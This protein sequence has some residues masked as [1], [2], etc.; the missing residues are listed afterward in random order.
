MDIN[1]N[2][3]PVNLALDR[4]TAIGIGNQVFLAGENTGAILRFQDE[5]PTVTGEG[6]DTA[7][8]FSALWPVR[9]GANN[10]LGSSNLNQSDLFTFTAV[11]AGANF[12][13]IVISSTDA[14]ITPAPV[15]GIVSGPTITIQGSATSG[16]NGAAPY[17]Q[18]DIQANGAM[19]DL[20]IEYRNLAN[21]PSQLNSGRFSFAFC[22]DTDQDGFPDFADSDTDGDGC[23]DAIEAGNSDPDG[24]GVLG[25]PPV[26]VDSV[27][28]VIGTAP[29]TGGYDGNSAATTDPSDESACMPQ[30]S[31][32]KVANMDT[33]LEEGD[34][35]TYTYTVTNTGN[36]SVNDIAMSDS[37]GGS[38]T[39]GAFMLG[40]L[41]NNSTFS[42][43][44][45][46]DI[47]FDYLAPTDVITFTADYTIT[48]A[49]IAA[50]ADIDNTATATGTP[51]GGTLVDPMAM[52]SVDLDINPEIGLS[53]SAGTPTLNA[54]WFK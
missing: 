16:T 27:G 10:T 6:M 11:G 47:D 15:G 38:G 48:A 40:V 44:D 51:Q 7:M 18:F 20:Q 50:G 29:V 24:D 17:A 1:G 43:D 32:T 52:E 21:I 3:T 46:A 4:P 12:Q 33:D 39:L 5:R 37:H 36:V 8:T 34:T 45:A 53:K 31:L 42:S 13:W 19:S 9:F 25:T 23:S 28:R 35:V 14:I 49:D 22:P 30:L 2:T 26:V 41:T 54:D